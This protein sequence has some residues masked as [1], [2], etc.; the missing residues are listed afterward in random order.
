MDA[1]LRTE[2]RAEI[3]MIHCRMLDTQFFPQAALNVKQTYGVEKRGL[4]QKFFTLIQNLNVSS[5]VLH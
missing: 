1:D 5:I 4:D 3:N 2:H